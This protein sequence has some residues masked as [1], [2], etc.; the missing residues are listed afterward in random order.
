LLKLRQ[1][2][3][4]LASI[5]HAAGLSATGDPALDASLP[6]EERSW[7]PESTVTAV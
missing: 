5:T 3:V 2:G 4:E 7:V 1:R 6:L